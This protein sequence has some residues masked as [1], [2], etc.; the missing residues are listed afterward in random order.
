M[1]IK[2]RKLKKEGF[3]KRWRLEKKTVDTSEVNEG[4]TGVAKNSGWWAVV[5]KNDNE[6]LYM[7]Y[8]VY[9]Q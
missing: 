7:L 1:N 5:K 6:K 2:K 3:Q 8:T 9:V 4:M